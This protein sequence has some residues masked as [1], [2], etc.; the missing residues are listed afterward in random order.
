LRKKKM[1]SQNKLTSTPILIAGT[2]ITQ[3]GELWDKSLSDLAEEVV[4]AALANMAATTSLQ[5][6]EIDAVFVANKAAANYQRQHHLGAV[7][8][9]LL[10]HHPP[11]MKIEGA[12]ASGGLALLTAEQALLSGQYQTVL[13]VGLEKMTD[14]SSAETTSILGGAADTVA[15]Y[16]STFP[17]LY[18]LLA[19]AHMQAFGTTRDH[20]SS[21]AVKNH[22]HAL[23]NPKAQFHT[24]LTAEAVSH[25][26]LIA[27]PL[28]LLDCSPISDGA[29]A[30]V[31]TTKPKVHTTKTQVRVA[32]FGH[33]QDTLTLAA[34][35]SLTELAATKQA[36][37][38]ALTLAG[39]KASDVAAAEV[40]DCFTIAE[41]LAI[42]DI[43][44]VP[45][46]QGG[47]ATA[48]NSLT[49]TINPSGGL[50]ACGHPVGA[51]GVKQ[52][53]FLANY[54]IEHKH[55]YGLTHNVGGSGATA[56]VHIL[57]QL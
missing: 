2:A 35:Q 51:T 37:H 42:E 29:A 19:Q 13:V 10:P 1:M 22:A 55:Q 3:F 16:G 48:T 9:N 57:E 39:I 56:V 17:G 4:A 30:V 40:H 26:Q 50:K 28:R 36:A 24:A 32:G 20:L 54:L 41:V 6:S 47:F 46:G 49:T 5:T 38:Q 25:S 23:T 7:I 31:L 53:A 27:D 14:V 15:E 44:F 34:R 12:C 43:G 8:S 11:G 52:L 33:G 45:K 18:A 21:V